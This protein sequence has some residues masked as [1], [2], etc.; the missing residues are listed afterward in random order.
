MAEIDTPVLHIS[1][2]ITGED[3]KT[4]LRNRGAHLFLKWVIIYLVV[5]V[6]VVLGTSLYAWLPDLKAGYITVGEWLGEVL[7]YSIQNTIMPYVFIGFVV[8]YGLFLILIR[9]VIA[10]KRM[11]ELYPGGTPI[12]YDFYDD[13]LVV[14]V[15]SVSAN[16]T[17]RLKYNSIRLKV[18][19][20]KYLFML[21]TGQKNKF[22]L[23]KT[24]MTPEEIE[25]V[26]GLLNAG[27][28]QHA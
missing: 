2:T 20:S 27:C 7:D 10:E 3:Y 17:F 18:S 28:L 13:K 9:P 1:G 26:R 25:K 4:V 5:I 8:L 24:I 15:N 22:S 21:S 23:Y 12:I 11:R 19:E 6:A 14:T 16:E